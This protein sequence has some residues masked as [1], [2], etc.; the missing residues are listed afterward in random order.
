AILVIVNYM[1]IQ[2]IDNNFL[3]PKIIGSKVSLNAFASIVA[4]IAGGALWGIPGM[5]LS[6]PLLAMIK[7]VCDRVDSL[8]PWGYLFGNSMPETSHV[9]Y[10]KRLKN[11]N[12]QHE[13]FR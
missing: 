3:V 4:V 8:Q 9:S 11:E 12:K 6:I 5:F 13:Q 7:V 1:I 2:F 10:F